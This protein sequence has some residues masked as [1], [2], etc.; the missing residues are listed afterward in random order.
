MLSI[1]ERLGICAQGYVC[2]CVCVCV[3]CVCACV[4]YFVCCVRVACV[5][6][7]VLKQQVDN[8]EIFNA[9]LFS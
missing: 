6:V 7:C 1:R 4:V 2:V 9:D 3:L 5:C 8:E